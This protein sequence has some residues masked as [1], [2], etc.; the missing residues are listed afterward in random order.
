ME[1]GTLKQL[2]MNLDNPSLE[3]EKEKSQLELLVN[4]FGKNRGRHYLYGIQYIYVVIFNA[5][6]V[7]I[8][9]TATHLI[10]NR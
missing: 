10:L 3:P 6:H 8:D 2:K 4:Y 7:F 1:N 5:F 9:I